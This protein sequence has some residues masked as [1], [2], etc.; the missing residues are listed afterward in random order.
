MR[1]AKLVLLPAL[2]LLVAACDNDAGQRR[3]AVTLR[4]GFF[5][6]ISHA[7]A[8][9]GV[10]TGIFARHL[11][12][13]VTLKTATFH[14]GPAAIE[15]LFSGG[16]DAVYVGPNPAINGYVRSKGQALRIVAGAT[17]GGA[18]LVVKPEINQ[19]EDLR[20]R[21]V[22]S[23]QLGNT[24][25]IA[26]RGWLHAHGLKADRLG[27]G[28]VKIV[29]QENAQT[30]T[31]FQTGLIAGA[32]VPE[33]WATRLIAEGGGKVLVDERDLWPGGLYVTTHLVVRYAFL[34][35]HPE[36]VQRLVN[37]HVEATACV[38]AHPEAAQLAVNN[39]LD[40]LSGRRLQD[41]VIRAAWPHLTFTNDPIAPSLHRS[42]GE[43]ASFGFLKM[44]QTSLDG[45]YDLSFLNQALRAAGQTEVAVQ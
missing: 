43:A 28:D 45:I 40:R 10:E 17:A 15:A 8:L 9:T 21:K 1:Y 13:D 37:G 18:Y 5:P 44:N 24:Q 35:R 19:P 42:A 39:A 16:L 27:G 29:P 36:L 4:L 20:G 22:A 14:A 32:W 12:P 41:S 34:K 2:L 11:G 25:D 33:P 3:D 38:N 26:L 7:T 6:S 30:L 31:A 23:P